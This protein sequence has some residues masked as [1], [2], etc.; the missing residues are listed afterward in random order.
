[1]KHGLMKHSLKGALFTILSCVK[2]SSF[3]AMHSCSVF[4]PH[5]LISFNEI[6]KTKRTRSRRREI[7]R[8]IDKEGGRCNLRRRLCRGSPS[9]R[10]KGRNSDAPAA[11]LAGAAD[12]SKPGTKALYGPGHGKHIDTAGE[13]EATKTRKGKGLGLA[14]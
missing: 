4:T 12:W 2:Q 11:L 10:R 7:R 3:Q 5:L 6:L 9:P 8:S 1:M 14:P 13:H